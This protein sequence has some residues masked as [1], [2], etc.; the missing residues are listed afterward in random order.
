MLETNL[1]S[2]K[3]KGVIFDFNGVILWDNHIHEA[4][5]KEFSRI[6]CSAPL[7][8]EEIDQ[9]LHGRTNRSILGYLFDGAIKGDQLIYFSKQKETIYQKL[10]LENKEEFQL[11]PG[12]PELFE[13]LASNQIPYTIATGA[14]KFNL[15]FYIE[16]LKLDQW[17][18]VTKIVYDDG[19][20][21]G[22]PAPDMFLQAAKN[23]L[24]SPSDCVV[25]ED[26]KPGIS[27]AKHASIGRIIGIGPKETH[28]ALLSLSGIHEVIESLGSID[29][30]RIFSGFL[31][32]SSFL[33]RN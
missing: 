24:R 30:E 18:D 22:K 32:S 19:T 2:K 15:D 1:G 20:I 3:F 4:A 29:K 16:H 10:C 26:S 33:H 11:S 6:F 7:T 17:F 12:A 5:W 27:A 21:S 23:I 25:I 9:H 14:D 8:T 13:F 28:S 31:S